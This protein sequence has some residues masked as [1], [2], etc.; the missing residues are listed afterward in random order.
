[1]QIRMATNLLSTDI[2]LVSVPVTGTHARQLL[3]GTCEIIRLMCEL[4]EISVN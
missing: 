1:M 3:S 4:G 2:H